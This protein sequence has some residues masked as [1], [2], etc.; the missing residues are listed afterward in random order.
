MSR[1]Q[2]N[3]QQQVALLRDEIERTSA[4]LESADSSVSWLAMVL[5]S[6]GLSVGTGILVSLSH[7]PEQDGE[8]YT[9]LW[10]ESPGSFWRFEITVPRKQG[11]APIVETF[12]RT[13][14]PIVHRSPGKG[15]TLGA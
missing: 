7:V 14:I 2:R 9:G 13:S 4:S 3:V 6:H 8:F 10:L 15:A 12:E 1:P 11:A 5:A